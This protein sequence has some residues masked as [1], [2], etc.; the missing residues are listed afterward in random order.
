MNTAAD[1]LAAMCAD[2]APSIQIFDLPPTSL[3]DTLAADATGTSRPRFAKLFQIRA[4]FP[5]CFKP[6]I[7][8]TLTSC[9]AVTVKDSVETWSSRAT[10]FSNWVNW[11]SS[12]LKPDP[13]KKSDMD[14][15]RG[16]RPK[17]APSS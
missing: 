5:Y 12:Q 9:N 2:L 14:D 10:P 11:W 17:P 1:A 6:G 16:R 3:I 8:Y 13:I 4:A 15:G 7:C